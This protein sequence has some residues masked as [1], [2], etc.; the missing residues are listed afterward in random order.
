MQAAR[1]SAVIIHTVN[2][3]GYRKWSELALSVLDNSVAAVVDL[4]SWPLTGLRF[5][6]RS[7]N[8]AFDAVSCATVPASS[9]GGPAN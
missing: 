3:A 2:P 6:H 5:R 1:A 8:V 7:E 9:E 4:R